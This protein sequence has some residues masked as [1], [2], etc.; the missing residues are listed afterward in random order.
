MTDIP[1]ESM[2]AFLRACREAAGRG[3][4]KCSSGN[5]SWRMD[6]KRMLVTTTRSWMSRLTA[7]SVAV[8]RIDDGSVLD[9][10]GKKPT[11]EAM[12]HAGV[13]RAR[14]DRDV[15]MHFQTPHAT[16]LAC[17]GASSINYFV[18]PEIPFYIG[19]VARVPYFLPGSTELAEAVTEA[20]REHDMVVMANHGQ[21]TVARDFDHAIQNAEFFELACQIIVRGPDAVTPLADECVR[22]LLALKQIAAH[23]AV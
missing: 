17:R 9:G 16:A 10:S 23:S 21:V 19:P 20:M 7:E 18:I 22:E 5:M 4:M 13:L 15:V 14:P 1:D 8:C 6:E 11:V 3:L 2:R 12:L